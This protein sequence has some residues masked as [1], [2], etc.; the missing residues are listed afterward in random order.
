MNMYKDLRDVIF[1]EAVRAFLSERL[2][3]M[4]K[5]YARYGMISP[6]NGLYAWAGERAY[7]ENGHY[8]GSFARNVFRW[9]QAKPENFTDLQ[10]EI[11]ALACPV[12]GGRTN[13]N[14]AYFFMGDSEDD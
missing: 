6:P 8:L 2:P 7:C 13:D 1:V 5:V 14:G 4:P 10:V 3:M 9:E 12:C 11:G